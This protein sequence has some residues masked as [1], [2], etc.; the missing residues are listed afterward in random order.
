MENDFVDSHSWGKKNFRHFK[1]LKKMIDT[2]KTQI[3]IC[4][5]AMLQN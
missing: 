4:Y 2:F 3:N 5:G 1:I